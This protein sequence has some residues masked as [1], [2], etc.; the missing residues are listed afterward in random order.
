MPVEQTCNPGATVLVVDEDVL[1]RIAIAEYLRDCGY[2]VIESSGGREARTILM[3]GLEIHILFADARLAGEDN[4][5]ALAQWA[6]RNRP[7]LQVMLNTGLLRKSEAAAH[8][9]SHSNSSPPATHL[10][11]RIESMTARHGRGIRDASRTRPCA[12]YR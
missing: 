6:R 10:R 9:C 3:H 1:A 11:E 8:L 12:A 7:G 4:G 2:R 5:F